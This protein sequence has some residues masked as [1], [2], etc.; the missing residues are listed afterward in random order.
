[1]ELYDK[2]DAD[3]VMPVD[4]DPYSPDIIMA[5]SWSFLHDEMNMDE[6]RDTSQ[7]Y[8]YERTDSVLTG[9][10]APDSLLIPSH[11]GT[12]LPGGLGD[13]HISFSAITGCITFGAAQPVSS[14]L[15]FPWLANDSLFPLT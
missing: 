13:D 12:R 6:L 7:D 4:E 3:F 10:P 5:N 8:W 14:G 15:S 9:N 2:V 1:M 11:I